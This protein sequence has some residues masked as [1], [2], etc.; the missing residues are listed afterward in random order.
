[1]VRCG[2]GS[3]KGLT[4]QVVAAV[5]GGV[6]SRLGQDGNTQATRHHVLEGLQ[7]AAFQYRQA[8]GVAVGDRLLQA[9]AGLQH[10]VAKAVPLAHQQYPV[11]GQLGRVDPGV[12]GKGVILGH[13]HHEGLLVYRPGDNVRL[14]EGQG[15]KNGVQLATGE[16]AAQV[17]GVAF[18]DVQGHLRRQF[19]QPGDQSREQVGPH[20]VNGA[21][22]QH[23]AQGVLAGLGQADEV[24]ALLQHGAGLGDDAFA[25]RGGRY[26]VAGALEQRHSQLLL[27]FLDGD[28]QG[29]LAHV[30]LLGR[31]AEVPRLAQCDY[32]TQFCQGHD[33][34]FSARLRIV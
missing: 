7:R 28:T 4:S 29:G 6:G 33:E 19:L 26:L 20:R 17:G 18:I 23:A 16:L 31:F 27:Q 14:G 22:R 1:M 25:D 30:A 21:H 3:A 9:G 5:L 24:V 10:L 34:R 11:P 32:V 13:Q 12:A 8:P 2:T 15:D